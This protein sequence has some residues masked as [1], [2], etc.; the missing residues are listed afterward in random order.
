VKTERITMENK[1][2]MKMW[3][4]FLAT[5][6]DNELTT[7]KKYEA[8]H[9]CNNQ[10][11]ADELAQLVLQGVKKATASLYLSYEF[12]NEEIPKVGDYNIITDWSG[13]AQCIIETIKVDIVPF[14]KVSEE[15]AATEGEGDK[16]LEFWK[17]VHWSFFK[18][19]MEEMGKEPTEDMLV[20]CQEFKVVFH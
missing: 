2:I 17:R 1:S 16:S 14:N 9:F 5:I 19:E 10:K 18:S 20:I 15:F 8:W 13:V 12:E 7:T 11:D 3:N 4:D 6:G